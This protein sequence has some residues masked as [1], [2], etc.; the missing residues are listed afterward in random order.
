M[1]KKLWIVDIDCLVV[2]I[3]CN[4][5]NND[6]DHKWK[7]SEKNIIRNNRKIKNKSHWKSSDENKEKKS[8]FP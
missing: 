7:L 8:K 3:N 2:C 1:K 6:N 4:H 5:M